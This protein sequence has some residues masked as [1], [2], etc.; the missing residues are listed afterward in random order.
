MCSKIRKGNDCRVVS[1]LKKGEVCIRAKWPIRLALNSGFRSKKRL[2]V[3]LLPPE[4][5]AS[6]LQGYPQH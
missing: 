4:W 6:L 2:G 5:D 1:K 3:F